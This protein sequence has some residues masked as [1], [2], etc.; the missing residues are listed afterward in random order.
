M[1]SPPSRNSKEKTVATERGR[2]FG[3]RAQGRPRHHRNE[4]R[5]SLVAPQLRQT[6]RCRWVVGTNVRHTSQA[7]AFGL[8]TVSVAQRSSQHTSR[9][10]DGVAA[11]FEPSSP[12]AARKR[13]LSASRAL[14]GA[15]LSAES[16]GSAGTL[17]FSL[18]LWADG[19]K[20]RKE[21]VNTATC[22]A[23][24]TSRLIE[25]YCARG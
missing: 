4:R 24:S 15:G 23:P 14:S 19:L 22:L 17:S 1:P 7:V 25:V 13:P 9:A 5:P 11:I 10:R 21:L 20:V 6:G 16:F 12:P 3:K 8:Q 2:D 18:A